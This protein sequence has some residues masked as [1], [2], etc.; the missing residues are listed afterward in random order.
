V[1]SGYFRKDRD[2]LWSR[3]VNPDTLTWEQFLRTT[4]WDGQKRSFAA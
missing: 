4:G 3:L 2:L 1:E